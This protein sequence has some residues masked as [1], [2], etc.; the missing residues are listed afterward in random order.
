MG[1]GYEKEFDSERLF[2]IHIINQIKFKFNR[3]IHTCMFVRYA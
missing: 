3:Y 1:E 2:Q